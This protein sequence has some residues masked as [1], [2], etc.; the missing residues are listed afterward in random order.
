V[1]PVIAFGFAG[2]VLADPEYRELL[3]LDE[4]S[5]RFGPVPV[6]LAVALLS[7]ALA[8]TVRHLQ[9][10]LSR[11]I[12]GVAGHLRE[13]I[14]AERAAAEARRERRS[15]ARRSSTRR[16]ERPGSSATAE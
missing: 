16:Q 12:R 7:V 5:D 4:L 14:E 6:V 3:Y 2:L 10:V 13:K 8:V 15:A 9:R 11:W 1:G